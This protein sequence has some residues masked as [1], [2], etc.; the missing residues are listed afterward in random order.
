MVYDAT[1]TRDLAVPTAEMASVTTPTLVLNG[2]GTWPLLRDAA[3]TLAGLLPKAEH[4]E[5]ADAHNH[6]IPVT[7]TAAAIREFLT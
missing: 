6:D 3:R 2:A 4:R 7:S 5:L 1:L